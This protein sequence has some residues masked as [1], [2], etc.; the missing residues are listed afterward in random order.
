MSTY[1]QFC[2]DKNVTGIA[3]YLP[4]DLLAMLQM[5]GTAKNPSLVKTAVIAYVNAAGLTTTQQVETD[6]GVEEFNVPLRY[7]PP[8]PAPKA[9]PKTLKELKDE[10][11][12][13]KAELEQVK[14][15]LPA[16]TPPAVKVDRKGNL[17]PVEAS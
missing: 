9:A 10:L 2:E 11:A 5:T 17:V 6:A 15:Q 3:V 16:P 8:A 14:V 7:T 12:R 13:V 1:S 4:N